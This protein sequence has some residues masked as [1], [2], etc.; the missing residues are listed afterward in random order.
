[1]SCEFV[2]ATHELLERLEATLPPMFYASLGPRLVAISSSVFA[3]IAATKKGSSARRRNGV[4][5][6]EQNMITNLPFSLTCAIDSTRF[7]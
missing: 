3:C 7:P 2:T 5:S 1:M 4:L 6:K